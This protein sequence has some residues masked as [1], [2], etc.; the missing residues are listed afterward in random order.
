MYQPSFH[1]EI[2]KLFSEKFFSPPF[3][4]PSSPLESLGEGFDFK[5]FL[6]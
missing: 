6:E 3:I 2:I 5:L 1:R 4:P